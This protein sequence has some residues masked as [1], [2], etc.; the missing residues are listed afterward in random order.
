[1][2]R[3]YI[4]PVL[5]TL[6]T[7]A[8]S[9]GCYTGL[10]A[11]NELG[12]GGTSAVDDGASDGEVPEPQDTECT[13]FD[14]GLRRLN[15][16]EY[17][18]ALRALLGDSIESGGFPADNSASGFDV[19]ASLL[20]VTGV[21]LATHA[22][23]AEAAVETALAQGS[24]TR[25][26]IMSCTPASAAEEVAC[27]EEI[28]GAFGLRAWRRP[29]QGDE[30]N[31]LIALIDVATSEGD[32]FE[33]GI[34]L[35]LQAIV[36]SPNFVFKVEQAREPG[37]VVDP[38]EL[39][40][41]LAFFLWSAPPDAELLAVAAA[42]DLQDPAVLQEQ[43]QRMLADPR[44][45][46]LTHGFA[47]Q[48]LHLDELEGFA[49]LPSIFP[50][51]D[52][53]LRDAMLAETRLTFAAALAEDLPLSELVA[54]RDVLVNERLAAH[55][56]IDGVIGDQFR[57]VDAA[58]ANRFGLLTQAAI[59]TLSSHPGQSSPTLRGLWVTDRLL[60]TAP[61]PPPPDVDN[62]L[63]EPGED[64][65]HQTIREFLEETHLANPECVGCHTYLDP[66]GFAL[67]RYDGVG[68]HRNTYANGAAIDDSGSLAGQPLEGAAGLSAALAEHPGLQ[69][70]VATYAVAYAT[71]RAPGKADSCP[72][73]ESIEAG[74]EIGLRSMFESIVQHPSFAAPALPED[75]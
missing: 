56:G 32:G 34:R 45:E 4:A 20:P 58:E 70:C 8:L 27:G 30:M 42:G 37:E 38:Y 54:A 49:P 40:T 43:A 35:A 62:T 75:A 74:D 61:P 46:A 13:G 68:G 18:N 22:A 72:V 47:S 26:E 15:L 21:W 55:Y 2:L 24:A 39:A 17:R 69:T 57:P 52:D 59:L 51:Y 28:L 14:S 19:D 31:S 66:V 36:L 29:V 23:V 48:W 33:E 1:M 5:F 71:N 53:E 41:R 73:E 65:E 9:T 63:P 12:S 60:C 67:E 3:R 16:R 10:D 11:M 25:D 64:G 6:A 7:P 44:A 50:E